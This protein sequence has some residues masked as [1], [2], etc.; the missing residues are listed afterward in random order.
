MK[1]R[2]I[3]ESLFLV[4][5]QFRT[6]VFSSVTRDCYGK[7]KVCNSL[8][9][10]NPNSWKD[11]FLQFKQTCIDDEEDKKGFYSTG[12]DEKFLEVTETIYSLYSLC[13]DSYPECRQQGN[14]CFCNVAM[15]NYRMC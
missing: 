1:L 12:F 4:L 8:S 11:D 13:H 6:L 9:A 15:K 14:D 3:K 2:H 7:N 5:L 10:R